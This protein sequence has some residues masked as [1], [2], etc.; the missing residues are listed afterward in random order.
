M[1]ELFVVHQLYKI[2][3]NTVAIYYS[4][5]LF[6]CSFF[7]LILFVFQWVEKFHDKFIENELDIIDTLA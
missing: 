1:N 2:I 7:C 3:F 6:K 5:N 4:N